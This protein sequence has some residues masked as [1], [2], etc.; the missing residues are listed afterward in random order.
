MD[1]REETGVVAETMKIHPTSHTP[2]MDIG[3]YNTPIM[4]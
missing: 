4:T 3:V 1:S 2:K